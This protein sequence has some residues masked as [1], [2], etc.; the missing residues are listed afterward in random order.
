MDSNWP[1][2]NTIGPSASLRFLMGRFVSLCV[3]MV[4][5][6]FLCVLIGFY[7][8]LGILMGPYESL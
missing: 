6:G 7:L 1:L 3:F 4:S 5:N 8:F 2:W